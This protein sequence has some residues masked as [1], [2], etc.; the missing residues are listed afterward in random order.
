MCI[1]MY[2]YVYIC[3]L[4]IYILYFLIPRFLVFFSSS[5]FISEEEKNLKRL[6]VS[7]KSC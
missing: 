7:K 4:D 5:A 1:Y 3:I 6:I 2:I